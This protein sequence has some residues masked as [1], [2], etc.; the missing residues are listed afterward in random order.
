MVIAHHLI[1]TAYGW[2]LPNDPR[3]SMSHLVE[4]DV[5]KQLG[6]IHHGRKRIQPVSR[7]IREFYNEATPLLKSR[8]L[9]FSPTD[10][11]ILAESFAQTILR[12][13]YT[14]YACAIMHDHVHLVVRKHRDQAEDMISKFQIASRV[15]ILERKGREAD[16]PVWGGCGW[17][18]F[19]DTPGDID[20]TIRY[21]EENPVKSHRPA[22]K[23]GFVS[24]YDGWPFHKRRR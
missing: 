5:L 1:W 17:K 13:V 3:G 14:C 18:V 8:L 7:E 15:A 23:W 19:L 9:Q 4:A 10:I 6:E 24:P 16:H 22:Q 12:E 11:Q 2:W 20:R 21:V